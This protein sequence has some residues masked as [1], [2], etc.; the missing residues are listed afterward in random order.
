MGNFCCIIW[1]NDGGCEVSVDNIYYLLPE[2][3]YR[4]FRLKR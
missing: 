2:R 3:K 1:Y 4:T